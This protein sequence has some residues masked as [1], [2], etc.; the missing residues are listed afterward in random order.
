MVDVLVI[1]DGA[2]EAPGASPSSLELARTPALDRLGA[3]G[4]RGWTTPLP[5]GV[6][7]G[8]ETAIASL[9]GW[10]PDGPVDRAALEAAARG[11]IPAPGERVWRVDIAGGHRLLLFGA[12]PLPEI[13]RARRLAGLARRRA[14]AAD[15]RRTHGRDRRRRRRDR[16]RR[17]DGCAGRDPAGDDRP[18]RLG[19]R[20]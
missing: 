2:S 19:P 5:A 13:R 7:V 14:A 16:A 12:P 17:A 8:S 9:L 18:A 20:R 6:P 11:L 1:L 15:P 4:A 3:A 10:T